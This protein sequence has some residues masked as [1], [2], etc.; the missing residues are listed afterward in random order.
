[1]VAPNELVVGQWT[2]VALTRDG[3][4][5]TIYTNGFVAVAQTVNNAYLP[6]DMPFC[7]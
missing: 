7:I 4:D 1:M 6:P 2:H 3:D 5:F